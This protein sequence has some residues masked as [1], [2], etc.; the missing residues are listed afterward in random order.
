MNLHNT[1][2]VARWEFFKNLK[3]PTFLIFTFLIPVIML[4]GGLIGYFAGSSA[5]RE[6]QSIAVI[7]ETGELFALLEAHLAP[8]PVTV[9]E[10]PVE[11]REQLAAQVGEG[12][13]DGY[14]HLT[15]EAVEQGR[16]NY[17]VP[18][19]RSQNTM[20]L[21]E[22]VRTVVTLYRMEKMGLTAAQIN[23]AT[24]PVTLQTRELSGEEASWAALVVPLVFGILLAFATMFTGQVLMYG[25]IKEKRNRIVEILL[26]SVSAFVLLMG[27]LLGFAA[28][29]LIQIAIWLAVG[30]TVAVRFLD[31]REIPLGF[32]ELAPSLLFFLGG[33]ILFSAMFAALG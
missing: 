1:A 17:Y 15:T 31:F 5:A 6:E 14:I 21:G 33:Y 11:K 7:D 32:A 23:A 4:A 27:K 8:T 22:G 12:E 20:V 13:F 2:R 25:V 26:S 19:S 28:L 29:G 16:V 10:F 24:M 18:D 3:S 30:L 9:T